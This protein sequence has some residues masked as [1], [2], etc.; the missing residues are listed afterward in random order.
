MHLIVNYYIINNVIELGGR[1]GGMF[2]LTLV[3]S[4]VFEFLLGVWFTFEVSVPKGRNNKP[5]IHNTCCAH[6][7]IVYE[8]NIFHTGDVAS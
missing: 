5:V 1:F 7:W 6:A 3:S 2:S 4:A 8:S